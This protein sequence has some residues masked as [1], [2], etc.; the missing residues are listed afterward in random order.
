MNFLKM[1]NSASSGNNPLLRNKILLYFI[2]LLSFFN[3]LLL[4]NSSDFWFVLI[5]GLVSF[6]T[7]FYSKNM[8]VIL[9]IGL[10]ITNVLKYGV[11]IRVNEG[12]DNIDSNPTPTPTPTPA[13]VKVPTLPTGETANDIISSLTKS[14]NIGSNIGNDDMNNLQ[15]K[16][17]D[18]VATQEKLMKNMSSLGPLLE[19]AEGF[20]TKYQGMKEKLEG[21]KTMREGMRNMR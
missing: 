20:L 9:C 5:F 15:K 21:M 16:A 8:I 12:L 7:S 18:L 6:L 4:A 2:V 10:V 1:F 14:M 13:P 3:I 19:K 11:K 17:D